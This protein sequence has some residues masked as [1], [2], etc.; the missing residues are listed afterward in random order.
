MIGMKA[1]YLDAGSGAAHPVT[2]AVIRAVRR[3]ISLPLLVGGGM[4][5]AEQVRAARTAG[6]DL[7]VVGTAVETDGADRI[8]ELV[9][10]LA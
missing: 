2:P 8:R 5:T 4:K 3:A 7:L 10:A 9:A 6:A 1:V